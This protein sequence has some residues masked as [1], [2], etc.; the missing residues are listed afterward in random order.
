MQH[1]CKVTVIDKK[2][3]LNFRP[4]TVPIPIQAHVH[5]IMLGMNLFLNAMEMRII[6]GIWDLILW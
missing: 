4:S 1:K 2:F 6:S 5:A 3:I